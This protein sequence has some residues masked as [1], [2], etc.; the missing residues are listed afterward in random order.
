MLLGAAVGD[1]LGLPSEGLSRQRIKRLF[2]GPLRHRFFFGHGMV[3]DDTEHLFMVAQ[4][5]L[6]E[7][8]NVE[9]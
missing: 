7:R 2:P 5:L 3:S 9:Q 4:A 6:D 1:A 8:E